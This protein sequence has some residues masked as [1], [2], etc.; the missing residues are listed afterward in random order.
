MYID[1]KLLNNILANQTTMYKNNYAKQPSGIY[2]RYERLIQHSNIN[3]AIH[4]INRLK[5]K[6]HMIIS[7]DTEKAFDKSNTHFMIKTLSK[8]GIDGIFLNLMKCICKNPT[9][10][11]IFNGEKLEAF[12]LIY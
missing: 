10:N 4:H 8:L 7:V 5:K 12:P 3:Y 6:N 1:V 2:P 11:I 9:A